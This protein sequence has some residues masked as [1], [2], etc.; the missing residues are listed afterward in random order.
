MYYFNVFA[1]LIFISAIG[2]VCNL[3]DDEDDDCGL[4][5]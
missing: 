5:D 2:W 1:V 4:F 3:L